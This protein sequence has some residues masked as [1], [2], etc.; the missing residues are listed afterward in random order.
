M[1]GYS[2]PGV[3]REEIE[4]PR[5]PAFRT[6]V[7]AFIGYTSSG[8]SDPTPIFAWPQFASTFGSNSAGHTAAAVRGFFQNGGELC[9]ILRLDDR[10]QSRDALS[11]ALDKLETVAEVD[12]LC[13]PEAMRSGEAGIDLQQQLIQWCDRGKERFA[14]LDPPLQSSVESVVSQWRELDG[15][16]AALYYPWIDVTSLVDDGT[17]TVPPC[18]HIAGLIARTDHQRGFFSAPANSP[19]EGVLDLRDV[20][21]DER[22][23]E[24]DPFGVVNCLRIFP[25]RGLRLWGARTISGEPDW[26]YINVRRLFLTFNRWLSAAMSTLVYE[27]NTPALWARVRRTITAYLDDLHRRGGLAG[28][29][30]QQAYFVR[31]DASTTPPSLR[32]NGQ[33]VAEIGIAPVVPAEFIV[34]T[35]VFGAGEF[36]IGGEHPPERET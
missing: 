3:Y 10:R 33:M 19:L 30:A 15:K 23:S 4:A 28:S 1:G 16:N 21:T 17:Q 35:L 6:G 7:P 2:I 13:M 26:R 5:R 31:C 22:Q 9:F 34:V 25:G 20:L 27:P 29:T 24:G 18:G 32:E 12:L 11:D 36:F 14:I 8:P